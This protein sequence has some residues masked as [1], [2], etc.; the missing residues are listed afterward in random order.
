MVTEND[1]DA[2]RITRDLVVG[3]LFSECAMK[4]AHFIDLCCKRGI[5]LPFMADV[6]GFMVG[7]E[8]E[9]GGI[10]RH[11]AKMITATACADVPKYPLIIGGSCGAGCLAMCGRAM[12]AAEAR[13]LGLAHEVVPANKLDETT[14]AE[15]DLALSCAP[16]AVA[17]TKRLAQ[18]VLRHNEADNLIY[19]V[20]R[21]ADFWETE[22]AREGMQGF[23]D[24]RKPSWHRKHAPR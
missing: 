4:A 10:A 17:M 13:R 20:D 15:L 19:T 9:E 23:F 7:R 8:A 21:L 12:P 18:Y 2:I 24:K 1:S 3:V 14:N 6:S 11:G 5:P 16:G 22:E